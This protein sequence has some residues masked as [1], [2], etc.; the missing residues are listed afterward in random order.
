MRHRTG[1]KPHPFTHA[2]ITDTLH[3]WSARTGIK[4]TTLFNRV[5]SGWPA[6]RIFSRPVKC[7]PDAQTGRRYAGVIS[8][9]N[10]WGRISP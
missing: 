5:Q 9:L 7:G 4:Y 2:G 8:E 1:R 6:E 10:H 3:G